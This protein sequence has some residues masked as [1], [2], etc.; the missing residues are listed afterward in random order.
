MVAENID[1]HSEVTLRAR[2]FLIV[3]VATLLAWTL[4]DSSA[5]EPSGAVLH[6]RAG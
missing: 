1:P 5:G 2:C 3:V 6:R 4:P